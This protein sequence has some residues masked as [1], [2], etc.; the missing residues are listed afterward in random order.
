[1]GN[2]VYNYFKDANKKSTKITPLIAYKTYLY[3]TFG[4]V[5]SS[6]PPKIQNGLIM[7]KQELIDNYINS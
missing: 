7:G 6:L 4:I 1:M 2:S 3:D 5:F